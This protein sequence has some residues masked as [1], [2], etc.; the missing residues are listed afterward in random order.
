MRFHHSMALAT[1]LALATLGSAQ[2]SVV[3]HNTRVIF[4][5]G[6][7]EVSLRLSNEGNGPSLVQVWVDDG[8]AAATP[9]MASAPFV[10]RPPMFRMDAGKSQVLRILHAGEPLPSDRESLF[11]FNLLEVPSANRG[12]AAAE[13]RLNLVT[14]TRLKLIYRPKGLQ[15]AGM[16]KAAAQLK[17]QLVSEAGTW[18]LKADNASPYH[19]NLNELRLR[20]NGSDTAVKA[21]VATPFS[22]TRF[23]L[24]SGSTRPAAAL[25]VEYVN[26]QGGTV[27]LPVTLPSG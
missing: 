26:D 27:S 21:S 20:V 13:Q 18:V 4:P 5:E 1:G 17:W 9:S 14:R 8:D 22:V 7:R 10:I 11:Y 3:T 24:P 19:I 25:Q 15:A 23:A 2:A 12:E 6:Q 16:N